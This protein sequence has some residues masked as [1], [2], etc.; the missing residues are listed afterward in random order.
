MIEWN[1]KSD[2][3]AVPVRVMRISSEL[4]PHIANPALHQADGVGSDGLYQ[5]IM[6]AVEPLLRQAGALA[7]KYGIR[8]TFHPGPYNV[9]G[10][11]HEDKFQNTIADLQWQ[12]DV[13]DRLGCDH[14]GVIVVHG[15]GLYG[16]KAETI[17]RWINNYS[18]LPRNVQRRLVLENCEKCFNIVDCLGVS[19]ATGVPVVFDTHHFEC[20]RKM[21]PTETFQPPEDYIAAV[22]ETWSRRGIKPK[23]H[24]S[25]QREGAAIGAH[26]DLIESLPGYLLSIPALYGVDIDIMVEAKLKEQAI[27]HL[28]TVY[29]Y[30]DPSHRHNT[31]NAERPQKLKLKVKLKIT[32][33]PPQKIKLKRLALGFVTHHHSMQPERALDN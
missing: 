24:V 27:R 19:A 21:H 31:D 11:P 4:L 8:L 30:L 2:T 13:L 14:N 32:E 18:R 10:T 22:L 12:A 20:Y 16:N 9:V 5:L 15:G 7:R 1:I 25:E 29:P 28:Y 3:H 6:D 26:S 33:A 17:R 23:F